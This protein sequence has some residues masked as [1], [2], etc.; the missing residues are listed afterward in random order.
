M[1]SRLYKILITFGGIPNEFMGW[2]SMRPTKCDQDQGNPTLCL[3]VRGQHEAKIGIFGCDTFTRVHIILNISKTMNN[4]NL[5]VY[6][7]SWFI[8]FQTF[9]PT[10]SIHFKLPSP[11][12]WHTWK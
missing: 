8:I 5:V 12:W 4:E 9:D 2:S 3:R 6:G 10:I 1:V 7:L 11:E